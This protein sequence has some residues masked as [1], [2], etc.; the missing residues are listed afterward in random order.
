[1]PGFPYTSWIA[2]ISI[3]VIIISMPFIPGQTSGLIAGIAMTILF[4]AIYLVMK[5]RG[6]T[7]KNTNTDKVENGRIDFRT[8]FTHEFSKE[9]TAEDNIPR[10]NKNNDIDKSNMK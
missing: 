1:M 2:L 3:I 7:E 9:L 10:D 8:G 5:A 6:K 4:I